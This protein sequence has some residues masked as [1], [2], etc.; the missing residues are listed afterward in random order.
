MRYKNRGQ[1]YEETL[2]GIKGIKHILRD[3]FNKNI[4]PFKEGK[5]DT[6]PQQGKDITITIDA[7][8]QAYGELLMKN[9]RG[10]VIAIEPA[11]GEI[12]AMVTAPSYNP[13]LLVGRDRSKNFTKLYY[14]TIAKPLFDRGLKA[15]YP[16]GSPFKVMNALVGLQ[17]GVVTI[18][19]R[20]A[21]RMGYYLGSKKLTGCHY[22][23]SPLDMN[24]GIAQSCNAYFANVYRRIIDKYKDP[25]EGMNVWS[26]HIK[27]FGLGD[28]LGYDLKIGNKGRIPDGDFYD[29]WY[30]ENRWV[31]TYNISNAIGQGEV[32]ATPIQLA[33]M[34]AAIGNRG[35]FYTPHIIKNIEGDTIPSQ[36]TTAKYTTID[37]QNFEP[38]VQGM[39]DV[40]NKGTAAS[41]QVK[42]IE[43]CGKTG[44]AENFMKIDSVKT[45]LTDHSIFV[46]FA[47]KDNPKIAIAVFVENGYWGSRFAGRIASLMIEKYIKGHITRTDLEEWLLKHSLED[48][49]AKPYSGEPF[50]INEGT[51]LQIV[52]EK[53]YY[54]LKKQLK[55]LN[56]VSN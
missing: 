12:L 46:A 45:Q 53:E 24:G 39:F 49:Y 7:E 31:S 4:G 51:T 48:E 13:N 29:R 47:P 27:S 23:K 30:G 40:Y 42:G 16:P 8:L 26:N 22:H 52:E 9:K 36:Y 18:E 11:T 56:N 55:N 37:K 15:Q 54:K 43:I 44:T 2:R 14:D 41:L 6:L 32:E 5:Y 35:Y 25:T 38:V 28:Y 34:V 33:N 10:G 3:R 21:C 17:E 50:R 19:D 20:F 1:S